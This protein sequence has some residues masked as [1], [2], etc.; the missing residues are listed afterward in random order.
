M[1]VI[2]ICLYYNINISRRTKIIIYQVYNLLM[3]DPKKF[4]TKKKARWYMKA[5]ESCNYQQKIISV[6]GPLLK[7]EDTLLDIGAGVG[8][9][10]VP[11]AKRVKRVT[12][13][14]P[15]PAM[16]E[17]LKN[18]AK[19]EGVSNITIIR[20]LWGDVSIE[21][22]DVVLIANTPVVKNREALKAVI[23]KATRLVILVI[24]MPEENKFFFKELYPVIFKREYTPKIDLKEV[25]SILD[26][27]KIK[28]NVKEVKYDFDQPFDNLEEAVEFWKEYMVLE[29][30]E[31]FLKKFLEK[32]LE[33]DGNGVRYPLRNSAQIIWF[34]PTF[35]LR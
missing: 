30:Y 21:P 4:W 32:R 17:E 28:Y 9:F 31:D 8:A 34:S 2:N 5:I 27:S 29:N 35:K 15:S 12:A 11:L 10:S 14:E 33:K 7:P 3:K 23:K 24:S 22:H 25:F 20:E 26:D 19:K 16:A 18:H 6:I 13:L 1:F